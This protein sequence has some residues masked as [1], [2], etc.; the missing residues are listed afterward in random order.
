MYIIYMYVYVYI[1]IYVYY[2]YIYII[3]NTEKY[4]TSRNIKIHKHADKKCRKYQQNCLLPWLEKVARFR[5]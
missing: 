5:V 2:I 1:F 4:Y 3:L